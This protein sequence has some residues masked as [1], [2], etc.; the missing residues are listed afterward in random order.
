MSMIKS[1]LSTLIAK[2]AQQHPDKQAILDASGPPVTYAGFMQVFDQAGAFF[3]AQDIKPWERI[4]LLSHAPISYALLGLTLMEKSVYIPLDEEQS[5]EQYRDYF[6]LLS[7]DILLTDLPEHPAALSAQKMGLGILQFRLNQE[8]T[9]CSFQGHWLQT[10][11]S[12]LQPDFK[13]ASQATIGTTSG[14]TSKPKIVPIT[15]E[16][17]LSSHHNMAQFYQFNEKTVTLVVVKKSRNGFTTAVTTALAVGGSCVILDGF[18][19]KDVQQAIASH[20]VTWFTAAPAVLHSFADYLQ[21][22]KESLSSYDLEFIRSSGAPL[23]KK[24][25]EVL[26]NIFG[27]PV[28]QTYGATETRMLTSTYHAPKGY[29]EGSVGISIGAKLKVQDGEILVSGPGVFPGYE[30]AAEPREQVFSDDWFHTGDLGYIDEDGYV[31]ITGRIK[32]MINRGGEKVSPY[33][34]EAAIVRHPF[35]ENTAV[36]PYP[37]DIGSEDVG[38]VIVP[39]KGAAITLSILRQHLKGQVSAYKMPTRLYCLD[40]IPTSDNHK[41]Q[42]KNLYQLLETNY[43]HTLCQ[44]EA[45]SSDVSSLPLTDTMMQLQTLWQSLLKRSSISLDAHFFDLGGDSLMLAI[46]LSELESKWG[47]VLST[48]DFFAHDTIRS[49]AFFLDGYEKQ[50]V[51][52]TY[53]VPIKPTGNRP[54]LF[55]LHT[56]D[57]EAVTYHRLG[58]YMHEDRPVYAIKFKPEAGWTHP[59][60]FKELATRYATE[61]RKLSPQGPYHVLGTCYG[62]VL[63]LAICAALIEAGGIIGSLS[64]LDAAPPK[65]NKKIYGKLLANSLHQILHMPWQEIGPLIR[66]K[67][68]SFIRLSLNRQRKKIYSLATKLHAPFL[69]RLGGYRAALSHAYATYER[70]FY[71]GTIHYFEAT[72]DKVQHHE[73][74]DYWASMA[75]HLAVIPMNCYH[76]YMHTDENTKVLISELE[77][78]MEE[79]DA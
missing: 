60:Q 61:I 17:I 31:F 72:L 77:K 78:I 11:S 53:L 16:N 45:S 58:W 69:Y 43:P 4:A 33:E 51:S 40:E 44:E 36:F 66:K 24:Q 28:Y 27:V 25:K 71:H 50:S 10:R 9:K 29:K 57:G 47:V 79:R 32:E 15:Y 42:R 21:Q 52:Y 26:E 49:L 35:I 23:P 56:G 68:R 6:E 63:G 14:T 8:Q 1:N 74:K 67:G 34:V 76:N 75:E 65:T 30:H 62:G 38:A 18:K 20:H 73:R 41:V 54:P 7:I 3:H 55:C 37:N 19:H 12:F 48:N 70:D 64:M 39:K 59:L 22:N 2:K 46:V 5:E 13:H